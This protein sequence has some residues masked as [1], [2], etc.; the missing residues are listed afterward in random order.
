MNRPNPVSLKHVTLEPSGVKNE[1]LIIPSS[2]SE[3]K[4]GAI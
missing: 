2:V 1:L 3:G 4:Q